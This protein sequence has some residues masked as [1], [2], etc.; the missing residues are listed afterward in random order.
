MWCIAYVRIL[1]Q[2]PHAPR[3]YGYADHRRCDAVDRIFDAGDRICDAGYRK[4]YAVQIHM[5]MRYIFI[6]EYE[7]EYYLLNVADIL[8]ESYKHVSVK[9]DFHHFLIYHFVIC[10]LFNCITIISCSFVVSIFINVKMAYGNMSLYIC[11]INGV[12]S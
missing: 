11:F 7:L 12:L 1:T 6:V 3:A 10:N 9:I 2:F 5:Y 8:A 4:C